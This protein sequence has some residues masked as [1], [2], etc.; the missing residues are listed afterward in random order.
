MEITPTN[1]FLLAGGYTCQNQTSQGQKG[2]IYSPNYPEMYP[3]GQY[4]M[5]RI[6]VKASFQVALIFTRFSLQSENN[7]DAVYVYDGNDQTGKVL[8]VFYGGRPP[9]RNGIYSSS[10]SLLVIFRSDKNGSF[11]GFQASYSA[12][13]CSG[14]S[15]L[16]DSITKLL[17]TIS[18]FE[19]YLKKIP[20]EKIL[21]QSNILQINNA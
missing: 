14:K 9:P 16:T 12:V 3:D 8:G 15:L 11:Y 13:K 1:F 19:M 18:E 21:I 6:V 17:S 7:T 2:V 5:W 4:C 10:N 20:E